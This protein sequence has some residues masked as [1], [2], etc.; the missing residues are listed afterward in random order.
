[1]KMISSL[2][3]NAA[4]FVSAVTL[5]FIGLVFPVFATP[6]IFH[7]TES[8]GPGDVIGLQGD[9]FGTA[10]QVFLYHVIGTESS[11]S[12]PTTLTLISLKVVSSSANYVSALI[13]TNQTT[14]LYAVWVYD[15]TNYSSLYALINAP[16]AWGA[17]DLC[18]TQ[19]DPS[20]AFRL[21]GR[22]LYLGSGT[23]AVT[24][25]N[26]S[27]VLNATVTTTG[28]DTNVLHVT[29]P[30]TLVAGTVYTVKVNN[31]YGGTY[32]TTAL[33]YTLTGR[34]GGTDSFGLG[35]PWGA[36]FTAIAGN[37]YNVMTD[38]RLTTHATGNG[39]TDDTAAIQNAINVA[40]GA[41]GGTVYFP[42]GTYLCSYATGVYLRL[43]SNVVLEG[44]SNTTATLVFTGANV[45]YYTWAI[46]GSSVVK[47]GIVNL[48]IHN[49]TT[50][51]ATDLGWGFSTEVFVLGVQ[52]TGDAGTVL[53]LSETSPNHQVLVKN[54][55]INDTET[56]VGSTYFMG[57]PI[58]IIDNIDAMFTGNTVSW[59]FARV[60]FNGNTRTL[61][62]NNTFTRQSIN[63]GTMVESGGLDV[64]QD[65]SVVVLNNTITKSGSVPL[66]Q[67]NDGETI[68][69][70]A[71][72]TANDT[73]TVGSSTSTTLTD[74]TKS[75]TTN[76]YSTPVPDGQT[77]YVVIIKGPGMGQ[78]RHITA[79]SATT[80]TVDTAWQVLP[81]SA[82]TYSI[83]FFD[84]CHQLIK[85][86]TL[87]QGPNGIEYY[88]GSCED[89]TLTGNT[90]TNNGGLYMSSDYR[91]KS[92]TSAYFGVNMDTQILGNTFSNPTSTYTETNSYSRLSLQTGST[93]ATAPTI[94]TNFFGA[95][96][97]N[98]TVTAPT[99]GGD[100]LGGSMGNGFG[101]GQFGPAEFNTIPAAVGVIFQGN[102]AINTLN[103]FHLDTGD[104]NTTIWNSD[105][106]GVTSLVYD[107]D[108]S[109]GATHASVNTFYGSL[110]G[111]WNFD[112]GT[113]ADSSGNNA[114]ATLVGSPVFSTDLPYTTLG[115]TYSLQLNKTNRVQV[116]SSPIIDPNDEMTIAFWMKADPTGTNYEGPLTKTIPDTAPGWGLQLTGA[117]FYIQIDT[118]AGVNQLK[119]GIP[120][121]LDNNWH[122]VAW[123]LNRGAIACYKDGVLV[124][125]GTYLH[126]TG[127]G[128]NG[129]PLE[130]G[131]GYNG[132]YGF[133]GKLDDVQIYQQALTAAEISELY[134]DY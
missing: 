63:N 131:S 17:N 77:Y 65:D 125:S 56:V 117:S 69:E 55:T 8:A 103:A 9:S 106:Q 62:E 95:E 61:V 96:V 122:H 30:S 27:T 128:G 99:T 67:D 72:N 111:E 81:T 112:S 107:V 105:L 41:G 39:T 110:T 42:A 113:A 76:L 127:F 26:G 129:L 1:M 130:I 64:S 68:L 57:E 29:A 37:V 82:S 48:G 108:E 71:G 20:R 88:V 5:F 74:S 22:N 100:G 123:V 54:S 132:G 118:S 94:G 53:E 126:G 18:G 11:I 52:L 80:L 51:A 44:A 90:S 87:S 6:T 98:N 121:L 19:I 28:S 58:Y 10:P 2:R 21:F 50:G 75:W 104:S 4:S 93:G 46:S 85:G 91:P 24:F 114:V 116:T 92:S 79:N 35:V 120:G 31:G 49:T 34:A 109:T 15:G 14:G 33:S 102:T 36:D 133:L 89:V 23:P 45:A 38:P 83:D 84:A 12:N 32:G 43:W 97:R 66:T 25:V 59:Y 47:S 40:Y 73:G 60:R 7:S 124:S 13:P 115:N 86:N 3:R 119:C 101:L 16:R 134:N 70:Q 78:F